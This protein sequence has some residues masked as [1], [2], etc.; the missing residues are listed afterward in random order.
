MCLI[1]IT[2]YKYALLLAASCIKRP[3]AW[4][5]ALVRLAEQ[6]SF[7]VYSLNLHK[8]GFNV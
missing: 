8:S 2:R 1:E 4:Y 3:L 7:D 5:I 6:L